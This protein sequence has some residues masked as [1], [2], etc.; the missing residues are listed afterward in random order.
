MK[1]GNAGSFKDDRQSIGQSRLNVVSAGKQGAN[2]WRLTVDA[3]LHIH[4]VTGDLGTLLSRFSGELQ[5]RT[6]QA[7]PELA[8]L[9]ALL[10]RDFRFRQLPMVLGET[11]CLVDFVP[12]STESLA[13]GGD[14]VLAVAVEENR[15]TLQMR[16]FLQ[17]IDPITDITRDGEILVDR[18]GM[19][20]MV[21]QSFADILNLRAQEMIGRHVHDCYP[22]SALSRLP[23]VMESGKPEI[24]EPH[25]L[26]GSHVV[27]N[28]WPLIKDGEVV[29]AYGK[30]LFRDI[31][32]VSRLAE[33]LNAMAPSQ[34]V[35][36]IRHGRKGNRY[37]ESHIICRAPGMLRIKQRIER[38]AQR[39]SSVLLEGESGTGKEL[40]AH[41]IH[42]ASPR[43]HAPMI[44]VNCAAIPE[45]LLE[46]ELFGYVD[47]AFTGARKGGQQGKF[48]Q[49]HGG[50]IF[51]DEI[52]DMSP[53]MQAKLLRVLQE[54]ELT[55]LGGNATR[56]VDVRV[57]A[58]TN[59][60]LQQMVRDK[61][62]RADL[63]YRLNV[64]SITIPALR[65][66]REDIPVLVRHF[67]QHFNR[68]FD[69]AIEGVTPEALDALRTYVYPGNVRELR[70][71]IESA[72][73]LTDGPLINLLDLPATISGGRVAPLEPTPGPQALDA[74]ASEI[75]MQSLQEVMEQIEKDLIAKVLEQVDGNKLNA[76]NVLG[77][78]RPGLYKKL[79]KYRLQ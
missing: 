54:K 44:R 14:L 16:D 40:F 76:A 1:K 49:A 41:A 51:L 65:E 69:M 71:A 23:Q 29:G 58:A 10:K 18:A 74:L 53:A 62:F 7:I 61:R 17:A 64:V 39:P 66:R 75:G 34:V 8:P 4:A 78:S 73:N 52:S 67:V 72:F 36:P 2:V 59:E 47:G 25:L 63:F 21:N 46:S 27:V 12:A 26:N 3:D 37:D 42:A 32:E 20:I 22:R 56:R 31:S 28:R 19:I 15:A 70:C 57:I 45:H 38:I 11:P 55:P 6:L 60:N 50:T 33:K 13:R 79:Q 48:E 43:R 35:V 68:E 77:I 30:I 24:G 5:G 9:H